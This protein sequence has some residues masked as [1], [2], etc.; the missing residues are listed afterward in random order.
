MPAVLLDSQGRV[1]TNGTGPYVVDDVFTPPTY[2]G[3]VDVEGL[4]ALG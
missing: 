1:L 4:T 2:T 3:T